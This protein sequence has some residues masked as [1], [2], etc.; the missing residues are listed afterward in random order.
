MNTPLRP[1]VVGALTVLA[2]FAGCSTAMSPPSPLATTKYT[3]ENNT[4][5][6]V[7]LDRPLAPAISCTGLRPHQRSDGRFEIVAN[8]RNSQD[9]PLLVQVNCVFKDANG[10]GIGDTTPYQT[11]KLDAHSTEAVRFTATTPMAKRYTIQVRE[12]PTL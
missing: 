3:I 9:R 5:E 11:L 12:S 10:F 2:L 8:V 1:T 4:E 6:F 7:V